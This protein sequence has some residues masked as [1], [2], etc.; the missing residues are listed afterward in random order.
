MNKPMVALV[1]A[2]VLLSCFIGILLYQLSVLQSLNYKITSENAELEDRNNYL[3]NQIAPITNR[4][5]ITYFAISGLRPVEEW[6]VWESNV[7][8]VIENLGINDVEGLVVDIVGFGDE[9]MAKIL[10]LDIIHVGEEKEIRTNVQ[11]VY[12]SY[13]TSVA[14]LFLN[15]LVLDEYSLDF[16]EVYPR[17]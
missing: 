8:V 12:G 2:I 3:E 10:Q 11:W 9:S 15:G 13:G 5:N 4:V 14:T 1:A 16:N 17:H 6:F 7:I